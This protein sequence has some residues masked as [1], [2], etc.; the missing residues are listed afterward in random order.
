[1][2]RRS[3]SLCAVLAAGLAILAAWLWLPARVPEGQQ[4]LT[5]LHDAQ[6]PEFAAAFDGAPSAARLVLLVSP[7]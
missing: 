4:P 6:T 3:L 5:T 7:T 1:M 2:T